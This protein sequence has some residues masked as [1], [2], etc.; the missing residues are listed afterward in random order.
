MLQKK[1]MKM[2]DLKSNVSVPLK[3]KVLVNYPISKAKNKNKVMIEQGTLHVRVWIKGT[4]ADVK[5]VHYCLSRNKIWINMPAKRG[6]IKE[7][8]CEYPIFSFTDRDTQRD[9]V[10]YTRTA[11]GS[12]M[13]GPTYKSFEKLEAEER[14]RIE[15]EKER[16]GR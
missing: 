3:V 6:K 12:F 13:K 4:S 8:D 2:Y 10:R 11:L 9:F 14:L 15:K 16:Q 5:S 7:T 1:P